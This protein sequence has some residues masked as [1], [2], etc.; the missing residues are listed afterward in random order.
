MFGKRSFDDGSILEVH[1]LVIGRFLEARVDLI[2]SETIKLEEMKWWNEGA[3][4]E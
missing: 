2:K 3:H 1:R 4:A